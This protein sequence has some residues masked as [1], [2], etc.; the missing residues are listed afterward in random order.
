MVDLRRRIEKLENRRGGTAPIRLK[1][2]DGNIRTI[3][4]DPFVLL[5]AV[6]T[7]RLAAELALVKE[8]ISISESG[9]HLVA[10][11]RALLLS[12]MDPPE[13]SICQEG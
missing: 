2:P 5:G 7:D 9:G 13:K 10:L 11:A 3:N 8:C 6:F 12:P 4:I 1:M